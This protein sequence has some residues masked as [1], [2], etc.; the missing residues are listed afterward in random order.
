MKN[1]DTPLLD[2]RNLSTSF[3]TEKGEVGAIQDVSFQIY[4]GETLALVGESGCGKSVTALSIM[5]LLD[6]PGKV[7]KG[8]ILFD[9]QD[10]TQASKPALQTI[11][12]NKIGMIFQEP[13]TSLNPVF[14]IG[15][16]I[17]EA[18]FT[19]KGFTKE[20]SKAESLRLLD[21]VEI[22]SPERRID[23]Y[24]HELSGGMKQRVMIAMALACGPDLLIAD[25]PTT[26][27]DV[28]IQAQIL[29]LLKALQDDMGMAILLITHN[30]GIVA[31]FAHDVVV[32]YASKIVEQTDVLTLFKN[33][34]HP[35]TKALLNALPQSKHPSTRLASIDGMV[36]SP[37]LY[38]RGCHFTPRCNE[39]LSHCMDKE[40]SLIQTDPTHATA[41]WLYERSED[42]QT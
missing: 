41:C 25:E 20:Q 1:S 18:L 10:L 9:D 26:A 14:R 7:V 35:Y 4:P 42:D 34:Q 36:P 28:T 5:Q 37:L 38:P 23:Q 39:R 17:G 6:Y 24:P 27:L 2:V 21:R 31:Q 33:P 8:Q 15:D 16:Q 3:F 30:L 29:D 22:P 32:M 13:M 40:P 12:G 19:H 11:R